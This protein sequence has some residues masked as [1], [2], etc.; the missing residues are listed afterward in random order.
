MFMRKRSNVFLISLGCAKNLVDSENMLGILEAKGF[1]F[2]CSVESAEIVLINTCGFIEAAVE[3]A[4]DTILEVVRL[5]KRGVVGKVVVTGCLVQRY[6]YKLFREIPEVDGWLGTGEFEHVADVLASDDSNAPVPFM[7]GRP[8]Y[9]ADHQVPRIRTTPSFSAYLKIAEGCSH[10]CSYCMIPS[11]RGP[12]RS[13]SPESLVKEAAQMVDQ[14][15][16]EMNLISQDTTFYG[17]DLDER[18]HLEDLLEQLAALDGIRWIRLLYCHPDRISNRLLEIIDSED[19]ICPYLDL[20]LQHV[21]KKILSAMG[22]EGHCDSPWDLLERI[23]CRRRKITLRTTLMVGFPGETEKDFAELCDFVRRAEFEHLGVFMF[24]QEKGTAAARFGQIVPQ[25]VAK[26]RQ[27]T[28]M[29]IQAEIAKKLNQRFVGNII[30]TL[31]EGPSSETDLLLQGRSAAMAPDVDDR[32]LINRGSGRV[33]E[34]MPVLIREAHAYDL[35]GE[36]VA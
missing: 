28:I 12:F 23:R 8:L 35:V 31:V 15:V 17:Q 1:S 9:L 27:D 11:L 19:V 14:G 10:K 2:A 29:G 13:R 5:K 21:S 36:I 26:T 24:S 33:G 7:I 22:R 4:V 34:I 20:P 3:E 25:T 6:G 16:I 32:I 30:P 18:I